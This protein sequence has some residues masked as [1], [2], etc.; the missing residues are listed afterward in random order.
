M[1]FQ[2]EHWRRLIRAAVIAVLLAAALLDIGCT[3]FGKSALNPTETM[4]LST[5]PLASRKAFGTGF[6]VAMKDKRARGG[7]VPVMVTST[8]L[9]SSAG[10]GAIYMPLRGFDAAGNLSVALLEVVPRRKGVPFYVQHPRLDVA[11]F[12]VR[13]PV[14][15]QVPLLLTL[16]E[17]ENLSSNADPRA[18]EEVAF[19]GFPE[20]QSTSLGMFPV[21]RSGKVASLDQSLFGLRSFLIP[22]TAGGRSF[23]PP[24]VGNLKSSEWWS[25]VSQRR[26]ASDFLWRSPSMPAPFGRPC[27]SWRNANGSKRIVAG[28]FGVLSTAEADSKATGQAGRALAGTRRQR[29]P[30]SASGVAR[31][32]RIASP[33]S[34]IL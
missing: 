20:G 32:L 7:V 26:G 24:S 3:T 5:Y 11:A 17:E 31:S 19:V 30:P 18:G 23:A 29:L 4:I 34:F 13:F 8:H 25:S 14:G 28:P 9:V 27:S 16:L 21:L 10:R 15:V 22:E 12:R 2:M 33:E 6:L 1:S